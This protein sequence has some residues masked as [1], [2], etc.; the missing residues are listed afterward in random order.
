M[1]LGRLLWLR[2]ALFGP[3][4]KLP[5]GPTYVGGLARCGDSSFES[6]VDPLPPPPLRSPCFPRPRPIPSRPPP[7]P[8]PSQTLSHAIQSSSVRSRR[9]SLVPL[10]AFF[11][12][13]LTAR[14]CLVAISMD[15]LFKS[16][17][18]SID[19]ATCSRWS[20][21]K[22][23]IFLNTS[24]SEISN[25]GG[26][27]CKVLYTLAHIEL[28]VVEISVKF[29]HCGLLY[30]LASHAHHL[31]RLLGVCGSLL[32]REAGLHLLRHRLQQRSQ[33]TMIF[34]IITD[35]VLNRIPETRHLQVHAH[36][37]RPL[38]VA[39]ARER[40]EDI[41]ARLFLMTRSTTTG[42][43]SPRFHRWRG[44]CDSDRQRR[45]GDCSPSPRWSC[46]QT[47]RPSSSLILI[48]IVCI[49]PLQIA[50]TL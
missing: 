2:S 13:S 48:P 14:R 33:C 47:S 32:A 35:P 21:T 49:Q 9:L 24:L 42:Y 45:G 37:Q 25:G 17:R 43:P 38:R 18:V 12:L 39:G 16:R 11:F 4:A 30:P 41:P 1:G 46:S 36:H 19:M 15:M 50:R 20:G 40:Q 3:V 28:E 6:V 22:W 8:S 7:L 5:T 44:T 31:D 10:E 26:V 29:I 34:T 27:L 23:R